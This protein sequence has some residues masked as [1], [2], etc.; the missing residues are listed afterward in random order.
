MSNYSIEV[1][2]AV[3]ALVVQQ[4]FYA[5]L[6]FDLL[7]LQE[8]DAVP[9]AA[10]DGANV[11][12]NPTFFKQITVQER[13]GVLAHEIT[14]VI[15]EH[16]LRGKGYTDLGVGPD[17][18][19]YNQKKMNYAMDY[20]I[21]Q[22]LHENGFKLPLGSLFNPQITSNDIADEVYCKIPDPPDDPN[23]GSGK[24]GSNWDNHMP[25]ANPAALPDKATIQRA[26]KMAESAAKQMGSMPA[27]L[28]RLVDEI[29][30]PQVKWT[31]YIR[32]T[33]VT[34]SGHDEQSWCKPN[35]RRLINPPHIYFPGRIGSRSGV[36][37][38]EVDTSGSIDDHAVSV[39]LAE[40]YGVL[41]D[42]Q[43][44]KLWVGFVDSKLCGGLHEIDDINEL[45]DLRAKVAGGG[46]TDMTVIFR[47]LEKENIAVDYVIILTDGY[48]PFGEDTGIPT[49]WCI[50]DE[51]I[52]APWGTTVHVKL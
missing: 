20:I 13:I 44:E 15:L 27:N 21:N 45:P 6:L 3:S 38:V 4:P 48:T 12:I 32:K 16:P 24:G 35:R 8:T 9:T 26:L 1:S 47:E 22:M 11:F 40:L 51:S 36:G 5:V 19:P 39:F 46:G 2:D 28:Q 33:L 14:H 23:D 41:Q 17:I 10:T 18:K 37:A 42:C 31:D 34:L 25:P 29:C 43:P 30:E 50:T 52:K 49:I 7:K